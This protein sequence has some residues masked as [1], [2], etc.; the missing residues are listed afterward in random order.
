M[1]RK[2]NGSA[3]WNF[4]EFLN[5]NSTSSAQSI[6]YN[7]I[8]ND[9]MTNINGRSKQINGTINDIN[10]AINARAKTSGIGELNLHQCT[11]AGSTE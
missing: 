5:K 8:V 4:I 3:G 7:F 6:D 11:S 1:S 10:R 9:L 2:N